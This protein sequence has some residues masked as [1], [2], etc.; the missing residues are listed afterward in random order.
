MRNQTLSHRER[1]RK[2][3]SEGF[4]ITPV[5]DRRIMSTSVGAH[6]RNRA[7]CSAILPAYHLV[8]QDEIGSVHIFNLAYWG[9]IATHFLL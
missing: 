7:L 3:R 5:T 1:V 8:L 2:Y 4:L 9:H 6:T